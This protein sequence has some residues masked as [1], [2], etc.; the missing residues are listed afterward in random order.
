MYDC[1]CGNCIDCGFHHDAGPPRTGRVVRIALG[2]DGFVHA[3][4]AERGA[5]VFPV[6]WVG[7]NHVD[8][9]PLCLSFDTVDEPVNCLNC[10]G[11]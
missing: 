8:P 10:L 11:A 4:Q 7:M 9:Y 3:I 1:F 5:A 2:P 6:C